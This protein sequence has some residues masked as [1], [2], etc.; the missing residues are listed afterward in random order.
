[1]QKIAMVVLSS[2]PRDV[3]VRREAEALMQEGNIVDVICITRRDEPSFEL[4]NNI[5]TYRISFRRSRSG[6]MNY[7]LDYFYFFSWAFLKLSILFFKKNMVSSMFI[8]CRTSWY[9][10]QYCQKY[11]LEKLYSIYTIPC[12]N[13]L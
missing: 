5:Q 2:F 6:K 9:I 7:L 3:R 12:L 13:S 1:M 8:I 4:V 10:L 11:F